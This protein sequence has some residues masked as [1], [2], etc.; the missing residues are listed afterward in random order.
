[1]ERRT[2]GPTGAAVSVIGQGT[3]QLRRPDHAERALRAGLEA[4]MNHIDTAELYKGS[5]EVVARVVKGRRADVFLVTKVRPPNTSYEGTIRSAMGSLKRLQVDQVD[6]L[7]Q[8]WTDDAHPIEE[9][10]RAFGQLLD[11]KRTKWVGVSNFE[12][13]EM[14]RAQSALGR[15]KIVC[16]QVYYSPEQRGAEHEVL[17]YCKKHNIAVVAYSPFGSGRPPAKG[18]PGWKALETVAARR[19]VTPFQVILAFLVREPNVF[20]IPKSESEAHARENAAAL[21]R[22]LTRED[23]GELE[24]AFP[25]PASTQLPMI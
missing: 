4:G 3:W 15:H 6:V 7:L 13:E 24:A 23:L 10:M 2:F 22:P 21:D 1:M 12:V 25:L 14:E 8:H 5:E 17:P 16:N 18:G 20:A 19:G 11:E 9:T